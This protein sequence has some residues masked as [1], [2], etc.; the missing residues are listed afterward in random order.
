MYWVR[1]ITVYHVFVK[2]ASIVNLYFTREQ[3]HLIVIIATSLE[4]IAIF[5]VQK[6]YYEKRN[7]CTP[8]LLRS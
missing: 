8:A 7:W 6:I 1:L 3:R 2:F 4:I 5:T